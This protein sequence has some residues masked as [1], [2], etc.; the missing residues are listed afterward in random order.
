V[1]TA[2][3]PLYEQACAGDLAAY[4]RLCQVYRA[5]VVAA[6]LAHG[7]GRTQTLE[8]AEA[9]LIK[10]FT[11][12]ETLPPSRFGRALIQLTDQ[13]ARQRPPEPPPSALEALVERGDLERRAGTGLVIRCDLEAAV[14]AIIRAV[15]PATRLSLT[16]RTYAGLPYSEIARLLDTT[17]AEVGSHLQQA[18]EALHSATSGDSKSPPEPPPPGQPQP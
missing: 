14:S 9:A 4:R 8:I 10:G 6:A 12:I 13:L 15:P 1:D 7:L 2:L 17:E 5:R 16:L 11:E 18:M 3:N